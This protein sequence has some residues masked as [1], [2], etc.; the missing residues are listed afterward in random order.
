MLLM[1]NG[2][3]SNYEALEI[4]VTSNKEHQIETQLTPRTKSLFQNFG[5][6][7]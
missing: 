3:I 6:V 4:K 1:A 5:S 7:F 2:A